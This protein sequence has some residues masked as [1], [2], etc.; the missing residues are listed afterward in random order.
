MRF[1]FASVRKELIRH[2]R[3]RLVFLIWLAIP[4]LIVVLL[5]LA[6]SSSAGGPP[7]VRLLVADLGDTWL[8]RVVDDVLHSPAAVG[9]L[10]LEWA[11]ELLEVEC[12]GPD[13]GR[14]RIDAGEASALLLLPAGL[15]EAILGGDRVEL[16]LYTNPSE[17][18]LPRIAEEVVG[19]LADVIFYAGQL[20]GPRLSELDGLASDEVAAALAGELERWIERADDTLFPPLMALVEARED[21]DEDTGPSP[22][23]RMF[24]GLLMMALCFMAEGLS[25]DIWQERERGTLARAL[26]TPGRGSA[27]VFGKVLAGGVLMIFVSATAG[28][29]VGLACDLDPV[30]VVLVVALFPFAGMS[31]QIAFL[32]LHVHARTQRAGNVL[33]SLILF[34]LLMAGGSFF[35]F[36]AMPDWLA[37]IGRATP[38]GWVLSNLTDVALFGAPP[39]I[40][41]LPAAVLL[42]VGACF[43]GLVLARLPRFV[44]P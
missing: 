4:V 13:E 34:P 7:R 37:T 31:F 40:L 27:L 32:A 10:R 8:G 11:E 26:A 42:G 43:G 12:V 9:R 35:P 30:A 29:V 20:L 1:L 28:I 23:E 36:D 18:V 16:V 5:N 15:N 21:E 38:N 33:G 19:A 2:S 17:R 3:D 41:L 24:P 14:A 22:F 44:L 25:S 6:V 39:A